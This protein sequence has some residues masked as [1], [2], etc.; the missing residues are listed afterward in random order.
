MIE[1]F[2]NADMI[3]R[4]LPADPIENA[5]AIDPIEPIDR[6][7]PS[8]PTDNT[9]PLDPTERIESLDQSERYERSDRAIFESYDIAIVG[10][11]LAIDPQLGGAPGV[12][13]RID[14]VAGNVG[15]PADVAMRPIARP[16]A[17]LVHHEVGM[18][19]ARPSVISGPLTPFV[20]TR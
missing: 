12:A 20:V 9:D 15:P 10:A 4:A 17:G 6:T 18:P 8:E 5:D 3:D 19:C 16:L 7:D 1:R 14:H 11:L 13:S 2:D